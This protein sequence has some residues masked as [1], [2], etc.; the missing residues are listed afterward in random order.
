MYKGRTEFNATKGD[1]LL[2][3][4]IVIGLLIATLASYYYKEDSWIIVVLSMMLLIGLGGILET[5]TS[6]ISLESDELRMRRSFK[7][8]VVKRSDINK[9]SNEKGCPIFLILHDK[10][11]IKIP[12]VGPNGIA[13]SIRAWIRTNSK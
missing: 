10:S 6:F 5:F 3:F 12:E 1:Y 9:V 2:A 11:K 8:L 4:S 7:S 13:N